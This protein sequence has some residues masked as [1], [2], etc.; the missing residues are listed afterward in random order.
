M[1][2][3]PLGF[4]FSLSGQFQEVAL[5]VACEAMT[6]LALSVFYVICSGK[7]GLGLL[8]LVVG[9]A[10]STSV[11]SIRVLQEFDSKDMSPLRWG[12][13]CKSSF[14]LQRS[15]ISQSFEIVYCCIVCM[16]LTNGVAPFD[17]VL[18]SDNLD[19]MVHHGEWKLQ[20]K[21]G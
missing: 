8:L 10:S 13:S 17:K 5:F 9:P 15:L 11:H 6:L 4:F 18:G 12:H 2:V 7:P 16:I 14:L 3:F 20:S 1:G 19:N 21:C